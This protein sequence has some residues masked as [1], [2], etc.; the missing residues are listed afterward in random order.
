M[1]FINIRMKGLLRMKKSLGFTLAEVLITLAIIGVVA[2]MTVPSVLQDTSQREY[3]TGIKKATTSLGQA[4]SMN[5]AMQGL[6]PDDL[7][8]DH[9]LRDY[10]SGALNVVR[11]VD[12]VAADADAGIE[13]KGPTLYTADGMS[14]S[15]VSDA[16]GT[17]AADDGT[18]A[19]T[20]AAP[21][22][23][24]V[25]VNGDKAPNRFARDAA[26]AEAIGTA[27]ADGE[28]TPLANDA[29]EALR[30]G[31]QFV[32]A[33]VGARVAPANDST[34]AALYQR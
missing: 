14:F 12:T 17:A 34:Y 1:E 10:L 4:I 26:G 33:I 28:V 23:V 2:A 7:D 27:I 22:F 25:D 16:N 19:C 30:F 29:A 18:D 6:A 32:L 21:C 8:A 20:L 11:N 24:L 15:L 31:D 9:S 3:I 5:V 13:A